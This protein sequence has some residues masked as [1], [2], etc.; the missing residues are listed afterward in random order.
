[1]K[2]KTARVGYLGAGVII[3]SGDEYKGLRRGEKK[4]GRA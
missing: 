1:M 4:S 3:S 2:K